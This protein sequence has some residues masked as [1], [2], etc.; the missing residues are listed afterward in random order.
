MTTLTMP[1]RTRPAALPL[2]RRIARD[3]GVPLSW[4]TSLDGDEYRLD[5]RRTDVERARAVARHV[6]GE[7]GIEWRV[8]GS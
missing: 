6:L 4:E 8:E 5:L 3:L 7:H 1:R 2:A